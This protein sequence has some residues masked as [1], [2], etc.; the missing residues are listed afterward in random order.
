M[1]ADAFCLCLMAPLLASGRVL[2]PQVLPS[3][4]ADP[5][6]EEGSLLPVPPVSYCTLQS[7]EDTL[8]TLVNTLEALCT[9][10]QKLQGTAELDIDL[11]H[12]SYRYISGLSLQQ[13]ACSGL[14][15]CVL[16]ILLHP[17]ATSG[18]S[19]CAGLSR[20]SPA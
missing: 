20:D 3:F 10:V 14:P 7:V 17:H 2:A 1:A 5:G 4:N 6:H 16:T 15:V 9:M 13:L 12:H 11:E 18:A 8:F 19:L